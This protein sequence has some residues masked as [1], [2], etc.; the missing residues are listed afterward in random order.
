MNS[1]GILLTNIG[2]PS[3]P[4]PA[5]VKKYLRQFLSDRRVV[6]IHPW[7]WQPILQSIILPFRAKKSADLYQ[8]IWT[9]QGSPLLLFSRRITIKLQQQ[10]N[11]PVAL[12]MHYSEPSIKEALRSLRERGCNKILVLPLFPQYSSAATGSSFELV[13]NELKTWRKVPQMH[14]V[15]DY[16]DHPAYIN[17]VAHQIQPFSSQHL[18]FSFHGIPAYSVD[19]GDPYKD[20]CFL[21]ANLVAVQLNL[22]SDQWSVAFQSRLGKA[23]WLMPYTDQV[24]K[25]FPQSGITSL[26]VVCP[27]FSVDCL[28]TLEEIAIRGKNTFLH[29]G[30]KQFEYIPALNDGDAQIDLLRNIVDR[31]EI[32]FHFQ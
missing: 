21:T 9:E 5:S 16:A 11:Q 1:F 17:A 2:T 8:K 23:Q 26:S 14:F 32:Q 7:L 31:H 30:G 28:E 15:D 22:R 29:A 20:R 24:L 3:A 10:L 25:Q 12:G 19:K 13:V 27:G 18:L 4:T 6:D